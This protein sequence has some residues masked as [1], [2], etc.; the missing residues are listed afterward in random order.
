MHDYKA[1]SVFV[2]VVEC[3]S[4]Q[5][6]AE[7]LEMTP[8]AIT[9]TV[10]KL[11]QQLNIKLLNRTTRRLYLTEA[12]ETFYK[13]AAEIEKSAN[14]AVKSIELL[15]SSPSGR[16]N[17][18]CVTGLTDNLFV[19][20]FKSMLDDHPDFKLNLIFEDKLTNLAEQQ[21]DIAIRAGEG[22]LEDHMIARQ[23]HALE[24]NIVASPDYLAN[25]AF[26]QDL[27]A[28]QALDWVGFSHLKHNQLTLTK[29]EK[30]V[31]ITPE[32]RVHCNTLYASRCLT[33]NGLGISIQPNLDVQP[34]LEKGELI[35]LFPEWQ[36]PKIPI[37]LVTLQRVQSEKVRIACEL[38]MDYFAP[39]DILPRL[40]S[41]DSY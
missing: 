19:K 9:Q 30:R 21:I 36:L 17:I 16:L 41:G 7:K 5:A 12:G 14:N 20:I 29:G 11:E 15:R 25:K 31:Q 32:Y 3:G 28:L 35:R 6:A 23:I 22:V 18:A 33:I 4:M 26:P 37:Y 13:H 38:I 8:S 39:F 34:M 2:T 24:W 27:G 40:K 1:M 10:Q